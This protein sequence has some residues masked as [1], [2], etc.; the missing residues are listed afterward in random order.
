MT[1]GFWSLGDPL[2]TA[3]NSYELKNKHFPDLSSPFKGYSIRLY[4]VPNVLAGLSS[5]AVVTAQP[6]MEASIKLTENLEQR[7][8]YYDR[9]AVDTNGFELSY[10]GCYRADSG[11]FSSGV[12]VTID[13]GSSYHQHAIVAAQGLSAI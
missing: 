8:V 6:A 10:D 4:Y 3:N 1:T 9:K 13:L 12:H 11:Q 2:C 5:P 7:S